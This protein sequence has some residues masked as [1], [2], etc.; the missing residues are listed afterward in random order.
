M[1]M[2]PVMPADKY[3]LQ[4]YRNDMR[5][6]Q[7]PQDLDTSAQLIP[8]KCVGVGLPRPNSK[9]TLRRYHAYRTNEA[10]AQT[11]AAVPTSSTKIYFVGVVFS[12]F[13]SSGRY[14]SIADASS[15]TTP[16]NT[17]ASTNMLFYTQNTAASTNTGSMF[18]PHPVEMLSGI[19]IY[20]DTM[21]ATG[22]T[23]ATI[24]YIEE[25]I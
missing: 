19:R 21:S 9:Q 8:V 24:Y 12:L 3:L 15:G 7:A 18:C 2:N 11:N 16:Q 17:N 1:N 5:T 6:S 22:Q 10:A 25:V 23:F 14:L 20:T 13:D 4:D